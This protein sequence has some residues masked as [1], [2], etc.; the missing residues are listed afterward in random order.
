V[1]AAVDALYLA[2]SPYPYRATMPACAHCVSD[3]DL[4]GLGAAPVRDVPADLLGRYARKAVSTWGEVDDFKRLLPR[5][6]ELSAA[7]H[8]GITPAVVTTKLQRANWQTWP[9]T[10]RRAVWRFLTV[11]WRHN[12][13]RWVGPGFAAHRILDAIAIAEADLDPYFSEWHH[14]LAGQTNARLPA[15]QHLVELLCESPLRV[16]APDT[17]A[18]LAPDAIGDAAKQYTAFLLDPATDEEL[19]RALGD[20]AS[21]EHARRLAVAYA[22]LRRFADAATRPELP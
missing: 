16:D 14:A 8:P 21:S 22:R 19:E 11:W 3:A 15:T 9:L 6:L 1:R 17:V 7:D 4:M 10:E 20:F 2:F 13:G 18:H 12:L 5:L